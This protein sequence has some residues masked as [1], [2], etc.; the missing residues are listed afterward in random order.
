MDM[1]QQSRTVTVSLPEK[2]VQQLEAMA[3]EEGR[4][5]GELPAEGFRRVLWSRIEKSL[6][7]SR[8]E[9]RARGGDK[10]TEDDVE[11]LV[12]EVRAEMAAER[13]AFSA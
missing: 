5:P 11:R 10:Y 1:R 8:S 7:M 12:H 13:E 9:S 6:E 4:D 3:V 2:L